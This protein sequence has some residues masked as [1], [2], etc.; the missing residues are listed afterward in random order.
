MDDA[1]NLKAWLTGIYE[2]NGYLTPELVRDAARPD[3]SPGHPHVFNVPI[4]EAAELHYLERAHDLIRRV[5]V[6]IV[7]QSDNAPRRVRFYHAIPGEEASYIYEPLTAIQQ[8]P[9]KLDAARKEAGRR[10]RDAEH[11]V[12]DLDAIASTAQTMSAVKAVRRARKLV[13]V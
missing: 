6:T 1:T 2:S 4:G 13:T 8:S 12:E 10:L 9:S 3:D 5:K 11:A 7:S